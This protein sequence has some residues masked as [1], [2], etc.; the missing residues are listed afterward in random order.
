MTGN[1]AYMFRD[2]GHRHVKDSLV[3]H[4]PLDLELCYVMRWSLKN[5][6]QWQMPAEMLKALLEEREAESSTAISDFVAIPH[7]ILEGEKTFRMAIVRAR[8]G[9]FFNENHPNVRSAFILMGT[10]DLRNL[11][12][13]ALAAIAQ[14]V[15]NEGFEENWLSLKN[16]REIKD[17]LLLSKR[18]RQAL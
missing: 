18:R 6:G 12:L 7:V 3:I 16:E 10:M 14:V 15:Q 4:Y 17:L 2:N 11:H 1:G 5:T 9:I 8:E 13:R